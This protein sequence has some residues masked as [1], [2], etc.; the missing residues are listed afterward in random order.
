MKIITHGLLGLVLLVSLPVT[1]FAAA[2]TNTDSNTDATSGDD[3]FTF[4]PNSNSYSGDNQGFY[5][6]VSVWRGFVVSAGR[7]DPTE[8]IGTGYYLDVN[9][10]SV[11]VNAGINTKKVGAFGGE[12]DVFP[13]AQDTQITNVYAGIGFSRVIQLQYGY[14]TEGGVYRVR[15]DINAR[16]IIDFLT[17]TRTPKSH[18]TLGDRLTFSFTVERYLDD[19]K[20]VFDNATWGIGLLF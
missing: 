8:N 10:T 9:Y 15:S 14:G 20:D 18:L 7:V 17:D 11:A 16:A 4:Y 3:Y 19:D 13:D 5:H 12:N 6:G 2:A 1:S